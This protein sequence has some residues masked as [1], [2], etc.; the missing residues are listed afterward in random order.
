MR[1]IDI[2]S[3]SGR[4]KHFQT[5]AI[6]FLQRQNYP[7]ESFRFSEIFILNDIKGGK[8]IPENISISRDF[9]KESGGRKNGN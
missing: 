4:R 2:N 7:G 5:I 3:S 8:D 1:L 9:Q 6:S